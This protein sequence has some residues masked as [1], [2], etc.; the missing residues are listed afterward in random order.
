[1]EG[2][3]LSLTSILPI[4]QVKP[5]DH[6]FGKYKSVVASIREIG[7]IEPLIVHPK[8]GSKDCYLLLDGHMRLKA[9]QEIGLSE[10]FCLISHDDDA[11]TYND[12]VNRL[13]LIQ[14]HAMIAKAIEHGVTEEQ[15]SR[16]LSINIG[17]VRAS[18]NLLEGIEPE[19]V[20]LLKEKPITASALR[21][22]RKAKP[23]RQID[24]AHLMVS[25][26]NYTW[27]YAEALIIGTPADQLREGT[28]RKQTHGISEEEVSR[29]E[30]EMESLERDYRLY[31]DR[32]GENALHLNAVQRYVKRLLDNVK[33]RRFLD[34]RYPELLEEFQALVSLESL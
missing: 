29:M 20:E 32:F 13:S 27:S 30:K 31:Q 28:K 11:F 4:R 2:I 9:M 18:L 15:I 22:F 26:N 24:M 12:K 34:T 17:K 19:A 16:A 8:R 3:T 25:S 23:T 5:T 10:A 1:M 6:A 7:L 14:E 33:V 21:L